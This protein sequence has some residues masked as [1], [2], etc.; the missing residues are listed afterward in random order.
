MKKQIAWI[1]K[2]RKEYEMRDL[3]DDHLKNVLNLISR[4]GGHDDFVN[5]EVIISLYREGVARGIKIRFGL[6]ELIEQRLRCY[7][8]IIGTHATW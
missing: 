7:G 6:K 8:G 1:D 2:D 5:K 3:T 4:G